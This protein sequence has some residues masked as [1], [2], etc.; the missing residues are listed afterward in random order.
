MIIVTK[1]GLRATAQTSM[2]LPQFKQ[3]CGMH[4]LSLNQWMS[5]IAP[6]Y[7]LNTGLAIVSLDDY[8]ERQHSAERKYSWYREINSF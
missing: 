4:L 1:H 3:N 2:T 5:Y 7:G 8:L 6:N